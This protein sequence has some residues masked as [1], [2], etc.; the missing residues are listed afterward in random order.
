MTQSGNN[1]R[2]LY[3]GMHDGVCTL[4]SSD[5]GSTWKQGKITS[6]D[7]A[8]ARFSWTRKDPSRAYLAAYE[9]G[10]YRTDDGGA[11]WN[12]LAAYPSAYAHSVL[13]HP[14][15]ADTA[16]VGSEPAGVFRTKDGGNS[17]EECSGFQTV[18]ESDQWFFHS[19]T[20]DSHI[21][22]LRM[23]PY[24]PKLMYAGI[25]VGGVIRSLDEGETWEQSL[26]TDP[27]IHFVDPCATIPGRVYLA[28]ASGP[29]RSDDG[30]RSWEMIDNGLQRHYTLHIT[31]A[32]DD[33][34]V[35]LVTVSKHAGRVE[36]QLYR[37]T[38][39]GKQWELVPEVGLDNDMVVAIDWDPG[40]PQRVY[41]GTDKGKVYCS[42]DRGRKWTQIGVDLGSLG[43]GALGVAPV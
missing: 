43:V 32:P 41:A 37:S 3:V 19:E 16:Y 8:A 31:A 23:A 39:G 25:E 15:D 12:H 35:V 4:S 36:P 6:L 21:R 42:N 20:R 10:V 40:E 26:G 7:H 24:D 27:D 2:K 22:D 11:T 14:D 5:S 34:D 17:W 18:P 29:Y 28:T 33:A 38:N 13:A 9:S 30:G 1:V